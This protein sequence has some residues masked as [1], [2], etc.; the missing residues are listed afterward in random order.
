MSEKAE[1]T[2]SLRR[3]VYP[4]G[5]EA[6]G[7][8]IVYFQVETDGN[9]DRCLAGGSVDVSQNDDKNS[10]DSSFIKFN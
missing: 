9:V 1:S 6:L 2:I 5:C 8:M 4:S 3:T 7:K 10:L